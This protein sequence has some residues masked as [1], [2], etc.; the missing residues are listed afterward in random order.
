MSKKD[1]TTLSQKVRLR[2]C[3]MAEIQ[4][5][6]VLETHGGK[7]EVW[8]YCYSRLPRGHS[9][10]TD[11]DKV[12]A[13]ARSAPHWCVYQG[14]SLHLLRNGIVAAV[15]ANFIDIDPYGDPWEFIGALFEAELPKV[16]AVVVND[17]LRTKLKIGGGWDVE[18]MQEEVLKYGNQ[19]ILGSYLEICHEKMGKTAAQRGYTLRRWEGW[20]CGHAKMMTHYSAIVSR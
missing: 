11:G 19:A 1:N 13:R 8:K 18:S 16:V 14:H 5:P 20:Y 12:D 3:A 2:K 9:I 6:V 7:G 17:G 10:D 4:D 15:G